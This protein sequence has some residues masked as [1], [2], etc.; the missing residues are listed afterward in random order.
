M[1]YVGMW[2]FLRHKLTLL[3]LPNV[4][5]SVSLL[6]LELLD[7][8]NHFVVKTV[9]IRSPEIKHIGIIV[10]KIACYPST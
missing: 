2:E 8:C 6:C 3:L 7:A 5:E 4:N 10:T 1:K 9:S